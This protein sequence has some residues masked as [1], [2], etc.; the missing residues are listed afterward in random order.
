MDPCNLALV[1]SSRALR[2]KQS[3]PSPRLRAS[4]PE[5]YAMARLYATHHAPVET[6][7][8]A[9]ENPAAFGGLV[10]QFAGDISIVV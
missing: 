9:H 2:A 7:L 1:P 5:P 4:I 6:Q 8:S 10:I 3:G